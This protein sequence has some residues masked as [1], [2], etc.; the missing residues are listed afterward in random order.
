MD[1]GFR[2]CCERGDRFV[3]AGL[4]GGEGAFHGVGVVDDWDIYAGAEG[5][6][7]DWPLQDSVHAGSVGMDCMRACPKWEGCRWYWSERLG[8][9]LSLRTDGK[10]DY[11]I[12]SLAN[13]LNFF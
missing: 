3:S 7:E 6:C 5:C 12:S 1:W 13:R 2:V 4:G 10:P 8:C 9:L 11:H